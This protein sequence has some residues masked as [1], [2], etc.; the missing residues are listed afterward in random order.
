MSKRYIQ[1]R[2]CKYSYA[3]DTKKKLNE[4]QEKSL[5]DIDKY[6]KSFGG[7]NTYEEF[8]RFIK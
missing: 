4:E 2:D 3:I 1:F 6:T 7:F 8:D 5:E